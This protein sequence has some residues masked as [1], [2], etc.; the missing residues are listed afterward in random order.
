M[1]VRKIK[2]DSLGDMLG[3]QLRRVSA[4]LKSALEAEFEPLGLRTSEATLLIA[5]GECPGRTQTEVGRDLRIKPANMVPLVAR[6]ATAGFLERVP[7]ARRAMTLQLTE[8]G[9][10]QLEEVRKALQ[11]HED[12]ITQSLSAQDKALVINALK[13]IAEQQCRRD[14]A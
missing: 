8:A 5:I 14:H 4:M 3:F 2:F 13:L 10:R 12:R 11:R 7:G 1:A 9:A 6:L